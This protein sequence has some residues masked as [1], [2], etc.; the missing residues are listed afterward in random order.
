[1]TDE[2]LIRYIIGQTDA[3]EIKQ[4]RAWLSVSDERAK[5]LARMKNCWI[6]SGLGN[7]VTQI[8]TEPEIRRILNQIRL[9][10]KKTPQK[11]L[12]PKFLKYAAVLL[13]MMGLSG[14]T[15]Y[16]ISKP[17]IPASKYARIIVPK[18][19][20]S[21]VVLSDGSVVQLNGGSL[22]KFP[23][24]F[25]S[26]KRTVFLE[27]EAFF[28]VA[29]DRLHPFIV[30]AGKLQVKVL[31]T[32]F[33]ISSYP[34][35]KTITTYL[36]EGKVEV[37]IDGKEGAFL[38]PTEALEY[39]KSTRKVVR[40]TM[41]DSRF[42]DWT[43]GILNIKGETIEELARKLERRFD[44]RIEFGDDEIRKHTYSGSIKDEN[45]YTVLEALRFASS[46][47]YEKNERNVILY[48]L[49]K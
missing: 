39:N 2:T 18:G 10:G 41:N 13:L 21:K 20:R 35:D 44:I 48:S 27:G 40:Q 3:G 34:D 30:E 9:A 47:K 15:G 45:L 8:I 29:R 33:N 31:G 5:E 43:N 26:G 1:M 37:R 32:K 49:K 11:T 23:P 24:S 36:E 19:E 38:K 42:S 17:D 6:L 4:I 25:H 28:D 7:E 22:L 16:F 12:R 14:A 46:L